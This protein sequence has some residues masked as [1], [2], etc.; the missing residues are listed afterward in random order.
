MELALR[1]DPAL[2]GFKRTVLS[3]DFCGNNVLV[4]YTP[5]GSWAIGILSKIAQCPQIPAG[6]AAW[7]PDQFTTDPTVIH[8]ARGTMVKRLYPAGPSGMSL[9]NGT[10]TIIVD[11]PALG[12]SVTPVFKAKIT[13][14]R[15]TATLYAYGTENTAD[16]GECSIYPGQGPIA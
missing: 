2:S 12:S 13:G 9:S 10:R 4:T 7:G 14:T 8:A 5:S 16:W 3:G 11:V 1:R 6:Q 15:G